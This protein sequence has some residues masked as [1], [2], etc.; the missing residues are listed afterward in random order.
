MKF[1]LVLLAAVIITTTAWAQ[2]PTGA[3]EVMERHQREAG[4]VLATELRAMLQP[5]EFSEQT[6]TI[7]IRKGRRQPESRVPF[8]VQAIPGTEKWKTIYRT[9]AGPHGGPEKLMIVHRPGLPNEYWFARTDRGHD[10]PELKRLSPREAERPLAGSDFWFTDLGLD[11]L[12]WPE[13][14][15]LPMERRLG[16]PCDVLD[17][18]ISDD[19]EVVRVRSWIDRE[20]GGILAAEAYNR[21]NRVVREFSVR[22]REEMN[23]L[24][25]AR[26]M[27]RFQRS[28]QD[29]RKVRVPRVEAA[30]LE[31]LEVEEVDRAVLLAPE[32]VGGQLPVGGAAYHGEGVPSVEIVAAPPY[33][34]DRT[35]TPDKVD[36]DGLVHLTRATI[37]ILHATAG[38]TARDW[39]S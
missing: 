22:V 32:A 30:V 26:N 15:K 1:L 17:S 38:I 21:Q 28:F 5:V 14:Q 20:T 19:R 10:F 29:V 24:S 3:A 35:D 9:G 4:Q 27:A 31:A 33:L 7:R 18:R 25:E 39:R 16:R 12:Y 23:F 37:R 13:Q 11:F 34:F 8:M 36:Q 6:G 2:P